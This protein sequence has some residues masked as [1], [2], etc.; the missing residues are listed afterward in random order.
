VGKAAALPDAPAATEM[1]DKELV[2]P[3]PTIARAGGEW[4]QRMRS[5]TAR[6][7]ESARTARW[8]QSDPQTPGLPE[9]IRHLEHGRANASGAW[10]S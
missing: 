3:A 1:T 9:S 6:V 5:E 2:E 4:F 10:K 7:E 8:M